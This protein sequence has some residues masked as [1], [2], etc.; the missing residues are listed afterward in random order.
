VNVST[1][2]VRCAACV[3]M[4]V[5]SSVISTSGHGNEQRDL[6]AG[7]QPPRALRVLAGDHRQRRGERGRDAGLRAGEALQQLRDR[8]AVGDVEAEDGSLREPG[9]AGA[10]S[11][12]N[13]H[14]LASLPPR[15]TAR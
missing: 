11:D 12:A 9:E 15:V 5:D 13:L 14:C 2:T 6:L 8:R 4:G 3:R 7:G 1:K 10:E